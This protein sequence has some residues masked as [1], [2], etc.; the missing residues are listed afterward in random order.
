MAGGGFDEGD[1]A[2]EVFVAVLF[3]G[4]FGI[5]LLCKIST[6]FSQQNFSTLLS[7][8]VWWTFVGTTLMTLYL[9]RRSEDRA[10]EKSPSP[11]IAIRVAGAGLSHAKVNISSD[12]GPVSGK[13]PEIARK[14]TYHSHI[15][16]ILLSVMWAINHSHTS[17]SKIRT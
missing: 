10:R 5:L 16:D 1:C 7:R 17:G 11:E 13:R 12:N 6:S 15:N 4:K 2:L 14:H 3:G 8:R 9:L